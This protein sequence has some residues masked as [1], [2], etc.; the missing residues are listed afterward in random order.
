MVAPSVGHSRISIIILNWNGK[1][2]LEDCLTSILHQ[3]VNETFEVLLVD[4]GSTDDSVKYVKERFSRV[5]VIELGK[6]YGFAEGNN[7]G[8]KHA[9]G[10]YLV[11]VNMDTKAENEWLK[12]LLKAAHQY[13]GYQI[14]C[15][16]QIPAQAENEVMSLSSF[17]DVIVTRQQSRQPTTSSLFASGACFLIR[18]EWVEKLGYLF[19]PYY[20]CMAEDVETS[21]RTILMG[22]LIGYV[23]DSRIY[24]HLGGSQFPPF[25]S[26]SFRTRNLLLTYYKLF[27][28]K[29][30]A[31]ML[32]VH[33]FYIAARLAASPRTAKKTV[34]MI[35][36]LV[37][38]FVCFR[39]YKT[40]GRGFIQKKKRRDEYVFER[41]LH[42]EG[43][44]D[45]LM[46]LIY[47]C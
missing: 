44:Q 25:W 15:S 4:N 45:I 38:F 8:L 18:R 41:F 24:H 27:T 17:G 9:Q 31:R 46:K 36:G 23:R 12:N 26:F 6:N 37:D 16:T 7:R 30:F 32:L 40:Y 22:G 39:R 13:P 2:W 10:E 1:R 3:D 28:P 43:I 20:F 11:F 5:R 33:F 34:G 19:D 29:N 47:R 35:K 21:L 42:K 14:L